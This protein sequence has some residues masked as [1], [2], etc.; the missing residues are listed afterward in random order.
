[1]FCLTLLSFPVHLYLH[2]VLVVSVMLVET[3]QQKF[4]KRVYSSLK[5]ILIFTLPG[6]FILRYSVEM[7]SVQM[8]A[9][10]MMGCGEQTVHACQVS[11][12]A[13]GLTC[14]NL[15]KLLKFQA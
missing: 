15:T 11:Q 2:S 8:M 1:M 4:L 5:S 14:V 13:G 7:S 6:G 12:V 9:S 10:A 3:N